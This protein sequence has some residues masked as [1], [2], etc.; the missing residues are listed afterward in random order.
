M[1]SASHQCSVLD[2]SA[3]AVTEWDTP[4]NVKEIEHGTDYFDRGSGTDFWWRRRILRLQPLG[5]CRRRRH[6]AGHRA[7]H[8]SDLL[9]AGSFLEET[10]ASPNCFQGEVG[11]STLNFITSCANN[12]VQ[13]RG[14]NRTA[15][16]LLT[17][18]LI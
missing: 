15:K 17:H 12:E 5:L 10:A 4:N 9:P 16:Q 7:S 3:R 14:I 13:N 6:W 2:C 18:N 11:T 8:P 1:Q